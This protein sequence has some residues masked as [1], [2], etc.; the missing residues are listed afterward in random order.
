V[1]FDLLLVHILEEKF[2]LVGRGSAAAGAHLHRE[3][4]RLRAV[5]VPLLLFLRPAY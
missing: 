5:V 2:S 1:I 3:A 4:R